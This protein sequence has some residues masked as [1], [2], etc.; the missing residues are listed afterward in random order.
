MKGTGALQPTHL[1][2]TPPDTVQ[3]IIL[4][5]GTA[6]AI[7]YSTGTHIVRLTGMTTANAQYNFYFNPTSTGAVI[8]SSG[9]STN[10]TAI[11][12]PILG[13]R[14]YQIPISSTGYS[15]VANTSGYVVAECWKLG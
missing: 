13:S 11:N 12:L 8:P 1:V 6:Q 4:A 9:T 3:T 2:Y 7:D 15:L 5:A 10:S 14:A